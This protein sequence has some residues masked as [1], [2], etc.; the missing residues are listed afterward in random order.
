MEARTP[1]ASKVAR[2]RMLAASLPAWVL[3]GALFGILAGLTFGE[4]MAVLQP[5]GVVYA[6]L[7]ESV[8]YPYILSSLIVGLGSLAPA[9]TRE[10]IRASWVLYLFLWIVVFTVIQTLAQAF[11]SPAPPIEI[12]PSA[13]ISVMD[14]VRTLVPENLTAALSQNLVP[15]IVVFAVMFGAAVQSVQSKASFLEVVET[16]RLASLRI[17]QWVVYLAPVGVFALFASTAGTI[18]P[19]MAGSL[20]VYLSLFLLGTLLLA[21]VLLPLALSAIAPVSWREILADLRPAFVLALVTTLPTSALPLIQ[22]ISER[23]IAAAGH[24]D[25]EA[26]DVTRATISLAYVFASL[27]NYFV[28][29]FIIYAAQHFRVSVDWVQKLLLPPITLLSSSGAPST[30]IS[31]A[32]FMAQWLGLPSETVPLYV[33]AM[34]VTR[35]GQV[36][37]SVSAYAFIGVAVPFMYFRCARWRP[38]RA[39]TAI[40]LGVVLFA[41]AASAVRALSNR[42]FS[43]ASNAAILD[44]T[45]DPDL[46]RDVQAVVYTANAEDLPPLAGP[47]TLDGI[48]DRGLLRV[49]YGRDVVP[50]DY[51][52]AAG[53]LVGF[54]IS[55]AYRLAHDLHVKLELAPFD[56]GQAQHDLIDRRLDIVMAGMYVTEKRLENLQATNPYFESPVAFIARSDRAR[57]FLTYDEVAKTGNLK[58]GALRDSAIFRLAQHLFPK[59]QIVPLATYD[60]FAHRPDVDAAVWSVDQ[61]H[62]W[63][64]GHPGYTA[65][66]ASGMG[67][68]LMFAY[69]LPP[70]ATTLTLYLNAWLALQT[71]NG[72]RDAQVAYWIEGKQRAPE[73]PRWN[74]LDN[75]LIPAW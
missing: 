33:E 46:I 55:Y 51:E 69:F 22:R 27:G 63:A 13:Q 48:R 6:M 38:V 45:L 17:W 7:L 67:A 59:A 15:A 26:K 57:Q 12:K 31:G 25:A 29:L 21:F 3:A 8:V 62:A 37:L 34:T 4:R 72:F 20:A 56:W 11:P 14:L 54:D 42:L 58:L 28:A 66:A 47:A 23:R 68:P 50:F 53:H 73:A 32:G 64:S 10:L 24:A 52:N 65:V 19:R 74:L 36:A 41:G 61:A 39:I 35:Y 70:D 1:T 40:A 75:V 5:A 71:N 2:G 43:P 30:T 9:R 44:R 18:E 16:I 49:G 60:E